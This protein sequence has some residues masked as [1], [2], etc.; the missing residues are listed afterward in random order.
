MDQRDIP[1][2]GTV[3]DP[4]LPFVERSNLSRGQLMIWTGQELDPSVPLYNMIYRFDLHG[5]VDETVFRA[6]HEALVDRTDAMRTVFFEEDGVPLQ[7]VLDPMEY[8]LELVDLSGEADPGEA[9]DAWILVRGRRIL[10]LGVC[11]FD[12]VLLKLGPDHFTWY[13]NQHHLTIDAWSG[14]LVFRN[15]SDLYRG[16]AEGAALEDGGYPSYADYLDY[17]RSLR[18]SAAHESATEYWKTLAGS[19]PPRARLYGRDL[20][21]R[22]GQT[23]RI[24]CPLGEERSRRLRELAET[25]GIRTLSLHMTLFNIFATV[26]TA[27]LWRVSGIHDQVIGTPSHNRSS[28][29]FRE[30]AG[31]FIE[32]FPKDR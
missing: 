27:Y 14:T 17:E 3:G 22:T 4:G 19:A 7:K 25:P 16:L 24:T 13:L 20:L 1:A 21:D 30:T 12:S 10:D 28:L 23:V 32:L 18:G 2:P 29:A 11:T 26:L 8:R 5:P 6:A 31:L 9:L 15:M